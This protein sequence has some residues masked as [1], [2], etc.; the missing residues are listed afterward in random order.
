MG[1]TI[2]D[3]AKKA[4]VSH[5]TVSMVLNHKGDKRVSENTRRRV[6]DIA[7]EIGYVPNRAAQALGLRRTN[8]VILWI[9]RFASADCARTIA[10]LEA[11]LFEDSVEIIVRG[12]GADRS[13][14]AEWPADAIIAI[15]NA[16]NRPVAPAE[17]RHKQTPFVSVGVYYDE[18][19][20]HVAIDL[21]QAVE[22]AMR[23]LI[24][25]GCRRIAHLINVRHSP[26]NAPDNDVRLSTYL[27][28]M[29]EAE[30]E[31]EVIYF[32]D[33]MRYDM[34]DVVAPVLSEYIA[35]NGCPD[36]L[37][38]RNDELAIGAYS[39]LRSIGMRIPDD[40]CIVGCDGIADTLYLDTAISTIVKPV[41]EMCRLAWQFVR[42]R[43]DDRDLPLQ[44]A[45]LS[46]KLDIR[47]S[48][49]RHA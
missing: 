45:R 22:E 17:L 13:H 36:G 29:H 3:I 24:A 46:A 33:D 2:F 9:R 28:V 18:L 32:P 34:R 25:Q 27:A 35:R 31:P 14:L 26:D 41:D 42:N 40:V 1:V 21:S 19:L 47:R 15:D 16:Y 8:E 43:L 48:S 38:C 5:M 23:H 30:L 6:L 49:L 20:D 39:H 11:L 7:N 12:V 37:F 44:H 10:C 4:N